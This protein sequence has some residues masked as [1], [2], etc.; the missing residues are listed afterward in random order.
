[1]ERRH[2]L[3]LHPALELSCETLYMRLVDAR[4]AGTAEA[5][6]ASIQDELRGVRELRMRDSEWLSRDDLGKWLAPLLDTFRAC[7][8]RV[9]L[10]PNR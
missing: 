1:M 9:T 7:A 10:L 6:R 4:A 2:F 8:G 5:L 3:G